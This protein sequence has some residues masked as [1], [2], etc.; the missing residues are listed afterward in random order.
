MEHASPWRAPSSLPQTA[1]PIPA[2][3]QLFFRWDW[4]CSFHKGQSIPGPLMRYAQK[5][6]GYSYCTSKYQKRDTPGS[7]PAFEEWHPIK[8]G[9]DKQRGHRV[10][11]PYSM[12]GY[13]EDGQLWSHEQHIC[14]N[15][16]ATQLPAKCSYS[17][18]TED[19][20]LQLKHKITSFKKRLSEGARYY[21]SK[22]SPALS[23]Q[24]LL[25]IFFPCGS[26]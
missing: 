8:R 26:I 15:L 10:I 12:E 22:N 25:L 20:L 23:R 18:S 5:H 7:S 1:S 19:Y 6:G 17:C 9:L 13:M 14:M 21:A 3:Q 16:E 11:Q 2:S 24:W 4:I